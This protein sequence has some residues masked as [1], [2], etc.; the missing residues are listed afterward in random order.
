M[1][2]RSKAS[3]KAREVAGAKDEA[4][5]GADDHAL[6]IEGQRLLAEAL[7]KLRE[8]YRK[9]VWQRY[10]EGL[11]PAQI[12]EREGVPAS[13]VRRRISVGLD[14]LRVELD[15]KYG[16]DREAWCLAL[17][18]LAGTRI[19]TSALGTTLLPLA[20]GVTL[21]KALLISLSVALVV[22]AFRTAVGENPETSLALTPEPDSVS[23]PDP[24]AV[25]G[26]S[27]A[28]SQL[29]AGVQGGSNIA[30]R[31]PIPEATLEEAPPFALL[32]RVVNADGLSIAGAEL[33]LEGGARAKTVSDSH[34]QFALPLPLDA[35]EHHRALKLHIK[36]AG[37]ATKYTDLGSELGDIQEGQSLDLGDWVLEAAGVISGRVLD[38]EGAALVG[39]TVVAKKHDQ[40]MFIPSKV[41]ERMGNITGVEETVTGSQGEFRIDALTPGLWVIASRAKEYLNGYSEPVRLIVDESLTGLELQL[42]PVPDELVIEGLVLTSAGEPSPYTEVAADVIGLSDGGKKI[43]T[44]DSHG[45]FRIEVSTIEPRTVIAWSEDEDQRS[46]QHNVMGGGRPLRLQLAP[47]VRA[48]LM[49]RSAGGKPVLS[50]MLVVY[51]GFDLTTNSRRGAG[52]EQSWNETPGYC[53]FPMPTAPFLLEV[54]SSQHQDLI[55]GPFDPEGIEDGIEIKLQGLGALRGRVHQNGVGVQG[56]RVQ[57]M[58]WVPIGRHMATNGFATT[59]RPAREIKEVLTDAQGA[60]VLFADL[61][62]FIRPG[63]P[64]PRFSL[65]AEKEGGGAAESPTFGTQGLGDELEVALEGLGS[66]SGEVQGPSDWE[67]IGASLGDGTVLAARIRSDGSFRFDHLRPG[68]WDLRPYH[69]SLLDGESYSSLPMGFEP[70]RAL[71]CHVHPGENTVLNIDVSQEQTRVRGQ[72]QLDSNYTWT[73]SLKARAFSD[74]V[75]HAFSRTVPLD[76]GEAFELLSVAH[77]LHDLTVLGK[78]DQGGQ[79]NI[80]YP[81]DLAG[82]QVNWHPTWETAPLQGTCPN[83]VNL[84]THDLW[85]S[86]EL[87]SGLK[88]D[89]RLRTNSTSAES[90]T[91]YSDR[92]PIGSGKL[93]AVLKPRGGVSHLS[94]PVGDVEVELGD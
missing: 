91:I 64:L 92:V 15:G 84:E 26:E 32:G 59:R 67:Y 37:Y 75:A 51:T 62:S 25:H 68:T 73:A 88:I 19:V 82:G 5:P 6:C 1:G 77:G 36:A 87:P 13:T 80:V 20:L 9:A 85:H 4:L 94:E 17:A 31:D 79:I 44:T 69:A 8:P 33:R 34:G 76:S 22:L 65:L 35:I 61:E 57:L 54:I 70:T 48:G 78:N 28:R 81:M 40:R 86:I 93:Y 21:M 11:T 41:A 43:T 16:G 60:F 45:E 71:K 74:R 50:Y 58:D 53:E 18:P 52:V 90:E 24:L 72:L 29:N 38:A 63:Q 83:G 30:A 89:T 49:V 14:H 56:A 46:I 66:I 3:R 39:A 55:A 23:E 12:A 42:D 7:G 2:Y 10:Y 47:T 27:S